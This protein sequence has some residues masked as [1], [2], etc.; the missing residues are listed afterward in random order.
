LQPGAALSAAI[1]NLNK[2]Y[3]IASTTGATV[4]WIGS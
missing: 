3:V 2:L 1:S 4:T